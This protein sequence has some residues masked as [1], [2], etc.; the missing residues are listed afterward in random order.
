MRKLSVLFIFISLSTICC[1][2][3]TYLK[4]NAAYWA[5]GIT[6]VSVETRL[7]KQWTFNTD[8]VVSPWKSISNNPF[9]FGMIMPEARF[10]PKGAF[11]GFYVGGF[12][13]FQV[14]K[15]SK[16]NYI[17]SGKYQKGRGFG[18]GVSLGYEFNINEKWKVD[19]FAGFGWQNS[20]YDGY[21]TNTGERYQEWNGSGEWLPYK[22]GISFAYKLG[23]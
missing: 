14:F 19:T 10:Y 4:G 11:N 16:W 2:S 5:V 7:A 17:N 22:I 15:M 9:M 3:Q 13:V 20:Q 18:L 23:K 1:L 8:A 21:Y 6:N 12:G